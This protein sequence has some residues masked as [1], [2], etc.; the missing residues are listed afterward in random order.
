MSSSPL[1]K[2]LALNGHS[3]NCVVAHVFL[4]NP[5]LLTSHKNN[6]P[7]CFYSAECCLLVRFFAMT[8]LSIFTSPEFVMILTSKIKQLLP[9]LIKIRGGVGVRF[10]I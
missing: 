9:P 10:Y 4:A 8:C 6:S 1:E 5:V 2:P 7:N 3:L